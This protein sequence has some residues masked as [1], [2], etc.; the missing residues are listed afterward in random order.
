MLS[1][2]LRDV[3]ENDAVNVGLKRRALRG[4]ATVSKS[5]G[6]RRTQVAAMD[7]VEC[8]QKVAVT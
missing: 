8:L 2:N 4:R 6:Q 7:M 1:A 5:R 3:V